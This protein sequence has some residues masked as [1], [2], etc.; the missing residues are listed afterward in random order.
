MFLINTDFL[1]ITA[2]SY[3]KCSISF[4]KNGR[5][6]NHKHKRPPTNLNLNVIK[7]SLSTQ[8]LY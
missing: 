4:D 7:A 1:L 6:F 3:K 2:I 8:Q 5:N